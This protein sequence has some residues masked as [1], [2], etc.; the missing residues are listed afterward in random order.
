[1]NESLRTK[2]MFTKHNCT[3]LRDAVFPAFCTDFPEVY[4]LINFNMLDAMVQAL[5][6][7]IFIYS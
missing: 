6:Y 7:E 4:A 5:F 1:M 3:Y 2:S